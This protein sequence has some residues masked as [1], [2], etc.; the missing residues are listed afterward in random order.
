MASPWETSAALQLLPGHHMKER[1]WCVVEAVDLASWDWDWPQTA[2]V[3]SGKSPSFSVSGL[4][5]ARWG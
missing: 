1:S 5:L 2:G 3:T 4:P